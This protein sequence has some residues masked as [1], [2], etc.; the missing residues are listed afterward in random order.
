MDQSEFTDFMAFKDE[1]QNLLGGSCWA[2]SINDEI[3]WNSF[4]ESR[5]IREIVRQEVVRRH[6]VSDP[7]DVLVY[8]YKNTKPSFMDIFMFGN[9]TIRFHVT[10]KP[11]KYTFTYFN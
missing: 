2:F 8:I 10:I 9:P 11:G 4:D 6:L 1:L 5:N 3:L 7:S